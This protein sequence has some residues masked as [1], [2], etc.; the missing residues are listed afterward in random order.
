M[1]E[2]KGELQTMKILFSN[3][4]NI[5]PSMFVYGVCRHVIEYGNY[6]EDNV[7][8]LFNYAVKEFKGEDSLNPLQ[9]QE[10]LKDLIQC[11]YYTKPVNFGKSDSRKMSK[12]ARI[13]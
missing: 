10:M 2:K 11:N 9:K 5:N 12:F 7:I 4:K 6:Y 3:I 1:Q 8:S 13:K